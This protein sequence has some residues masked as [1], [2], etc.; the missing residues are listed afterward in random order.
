MSR[1]SE[2]GRRRISEASRAKWADP[3]Y[4]KRMAVVASRIMRENWKK[5]SFRRNVASAGSERMRQFN[6]TDKMREAARVSM[7]RKK[8]DPSFESRRTKAASK[9][10]SSYNRKHK[11]LETSARWKDQSY[12]DEMATVHRRQGIEKCSGLE[13]R[14]LQF[15]KQFGYEPI[16]QFKIDLGDGYTLVDAYIPALKLC[17]YADGAYWHGKT[18]AIIKDGKVNES[19]PALGFTVFRIREKHASEDLA[20][21]AAVL[22]GAR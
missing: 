5:E 8:A 15:V 12:R 22:E 2:E 7:E 11:S 9:A 16:R 20:N 21:L 14:V 4:R 1:L 3:D 19:L 6:K 13:K 17:I 18:R 10:L